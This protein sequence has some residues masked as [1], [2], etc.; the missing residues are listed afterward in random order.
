ML[1]EEGFKK[2]CFIPSTR[3]PTIYDTH[4]ILTINGSPYEVDPLTSMEEKKT[5]KMT[6][7]DK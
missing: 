6:R 1:Y 7:C 3:G 2:K 5:R 4:R